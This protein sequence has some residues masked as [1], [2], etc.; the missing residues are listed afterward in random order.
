MHVI[1]WL[2]DSVLS[3]VRALFRTLFPFSSS[4]ILA[5][6]TSAVWLIV[7]VRSKDGA[8]RYTIS[9][10]TNI[11]GKTMQTPGAGTYELK[12]TVGINAPKITISYFKILNFDYSIII[13]LTKQLLIFVPVWQRPP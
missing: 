9:L 6:I 11:E 3:L 13:Y 2:A 8:P 12:S 1:I 10:K 5:Y 7:F 4:H